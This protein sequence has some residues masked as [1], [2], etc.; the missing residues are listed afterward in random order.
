[1][2]GG[3]I[4]AAAL[5]AASIAAA[6]GTVA[7]VVRAVPAVQSEP[8][9]GG[10]AYA[11]RERYARRFD[12]ARLKNVVVYAEPGARPPSTDQ[13]SVLVLKRDRHGVQV[14]PGF[15]AARAGA[16]IE[17]VNET[18]G[19]LGLSTGED[20]ADQW[21]REAAAGER[22]D[23]RLSKPGLYRVSW[24]PQNAAPFESSVYLAAGA[25]ALADADGRYE[26]A[27]PAGEHAVTAW[28]ERFP[29][30]EKKVTVKD[31][32]KH[33]LDFALSVRDLPAVK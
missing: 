17:V 16:S 21:A 24:R 6:E 8:A 33:E 28:H 15:L 9:D 3:L 14:E 32:E 1:M 11:G 10:G 27:L 29:S 7:G 23:L 2:K 19:R 5:A 18:G 25:F 30:S 31:G 12:Y 4:L 22:L 13:G 26:L 20:S